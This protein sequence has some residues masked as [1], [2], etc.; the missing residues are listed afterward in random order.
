MRARAGTRRGLR[1]AEQTWKP[2]WA[3]VVDV[4]VDATTALDG[5]L[6]LQDVRVVVRVQRAGPAAAVFVRVIVRTAARGSFALIPTVVVAL[7]MMV[8]VVFCAIAML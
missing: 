2:G 6:V 8:V 3:R 4:R 1:E 5:P 7:V